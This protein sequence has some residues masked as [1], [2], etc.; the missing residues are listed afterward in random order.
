MKF[1]DQE[2]NEKNRYKL[3]IHILASEWEHLLQKANIPT[4]FARVQF[5]ICSN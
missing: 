3:I 4:I 2:K 5:S 1:Q